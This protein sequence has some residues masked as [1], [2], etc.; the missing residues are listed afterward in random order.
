MTERLRDNLG[1]CALLVLPASDVDFLI[2]VVD[3]SALN[4]PPQGVHYGYPDRQNVSGG[5]FNTSGL[6]TS[7][8]NDIPLNETGTGWISTTGIIKL[9]LRSSTDIAAAAPTGREHM[10]V[11]ASEQGLG[12]QPRLVVTYTTP[13][14]GGEAYPVSKVSLLAPWIAGGIVSAGSLTWYVLRRRTIQS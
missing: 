4:E 7:G 2:T 6:N 14:V 9:A 3:G 12:Y 10:G 1:P 13:P 8:Y 11:Y 5:S